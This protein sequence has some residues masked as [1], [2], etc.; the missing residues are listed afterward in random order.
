MV[1]YGNVGLVGRGIEGVIANN[2]FKIIPH[3]PLTNNYLYYYLTQPLV[4]EYIVASCGGSAMPSI[5]HSTIGDLIIKLPSAELLTKFD[6]FAASTEK[7]I[8]INEKEIVLLR[9]ESSMLLAQFLNR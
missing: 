8:R 4:Y 2:M 7:T 6:V 5:K 9:N 1:R 3:T